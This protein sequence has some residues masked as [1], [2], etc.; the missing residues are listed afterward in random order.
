MNIRDAPMVYPIE[1]AGLVARYIPTPHAAP[2]A[3]W[4]P[5]ETPGMRNPFWRDDV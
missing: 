5:G 1:V 2:W 4:M 3:I